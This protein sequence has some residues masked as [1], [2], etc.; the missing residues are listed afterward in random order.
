VRKQCGE[1]SLL[2]T[3]DIY[4]AELALHRDM[5]LAAGMPPTDMLYSQLRIYEKGDR[6]TR[7][8]RR[9]GGRERERER[10]R[11][12]KETKASERARRYGSSSQ[13]VSG[14]S[15]MIGI[16]DWRG[17]LIK[18]S[19]TNRGAYREGHN[20]CCRLLL[21]LVEEGEHLRIS[22]TCVR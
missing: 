17:N 4:E 16:A 1:G 5:M 11:S 7:G 20:R 6:R 15:S 9:E 2:C 12:E 18:N 13:T 10:E 3:G 8:A 19:R 22:R 21:G 14:M